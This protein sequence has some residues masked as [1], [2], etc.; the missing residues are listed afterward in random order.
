MPW[1]W[2]M[3]VHCMDL[4]RGTFHHWPIEGGWRANQLYLDLMLAVWKA[5]QFFQKLPSEW[6]EV[7]VDYK[8][9]L[10]DGRPQTEEMTRYERWLAERDR[11]QA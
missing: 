6:D 4:W 8:E 1:P 7:D 3:A 10:D 2:H 9:W 11:T 5:W